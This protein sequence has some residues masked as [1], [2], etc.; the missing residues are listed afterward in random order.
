[1]TE[2]FILYF[3]YYKNVMLYRYITYSKNKLKYI[4]VTGIN[5]LKSEL[6][7]KEKIKNFILSQFWKLEVRK[8]MLSLK[9]LENSPS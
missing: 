2:I 4:H 5:H 1:M 6:S 9:A 7:S 3:L 8:A